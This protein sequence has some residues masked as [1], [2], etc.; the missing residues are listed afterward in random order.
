M[1]RYSLFTLIF[2]IP[3]TSVCFSSCQGEALVDTFLLDENISLPQAILHG[4]TLMG[5]QVAVSKYDGEIYAH[6]SKIL[7]S[8]GIG[9]CVYNGNDLSTQEGVAGQTIRLSVFNIDDPHKKKIFD[10]F[11]ENVEYKTLKLDKNYPCYTPVCFLTEEKKIRVLCKVYVNLVQKCYFRDFDPKTE[12]FSDPQVSKIKINSTNELID[13]DILNVRKHLKYLFGE[14]YQLSTDFMFLSAEPL[15]KGN[16]SYMG[17]TIGVFSTNWIKDSGTTIL[18]KTNDAGKTFD[19]IGAPD[20]SS[21]KSKY[22]SQFVEGAFIFNSENELIA[23]GR[24]SLGGIMYTKSTDG[25]YKFETPYALNEECNFNT[26]ASK[27][28]FIKINNGY[29]SVWNTRENFGNTNSRTVL[30]IRYGSNPKVCNNPVKIVIK[31]EFGCHYPSIYKYNNKYYL[32]YTTDSRRFN[33]NSTG[34]IAFV[35]LPF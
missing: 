11:K 25:G 34:E 35:K 27:M 12:T 5:K 31:N 3:L 1:K 20:G 2:F 16:T 14:K 17:L 8:D 19:L 9:Y 26:L 23:L 30:E 21:I 4:N 15:N 28:N 13:F 22:N 24:N 33:R 7:I 6:D 29:L 32:T 10:V 18:L